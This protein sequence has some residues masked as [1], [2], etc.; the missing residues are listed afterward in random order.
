[1]ID[2]KTVV[3]YVPDRVDAEIGDVILFKFFAAAHSVTQSEF[4]T[5]CTPKQGGFDS[6]LIPNPNNTDS[7]M[8]ER[9]FTVTTKSPLWF[10]CKQPVKN[11]CGQ[12][13]VF[14]INPNGKMD[15]FISKAKAQNGA[16]VTQTVS[17]TSTSAAATTSAVY[18]APPPS[19]FTV[20]V[21]GGINLTANTNT[22]KF[23]P[24]LIPRVEKGTK[25]VFDFRKLNHTL[26]ES[27]FANP[28]MKK[29][30]GL[31]TDFHNFNANDVPGQNTTTFVIDSDPSTPR[32]F[33]CKQANGKA[34]G[35][36]HNGMVF[37]INTDMGTFQ[38]FKENAEKTPVTLPGKRT[39]RYDA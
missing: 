20:V 30:G 17:A 7:A 35:H 8:F 26:T 29:P 23:D 39:K 5:P 6:G 21:E 14:G 37:A 10:Y 15:E 38:K 13:M 19:T 4:M 11:H 3:H 27:T 33:Y 2:G 22:L 12:G 18:Q 36:C 16:L 24:P 31:D 9:P 1:M 25:L 34:N 32:W 28:C